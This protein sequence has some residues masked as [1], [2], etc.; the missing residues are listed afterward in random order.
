MTDH[1]STL[2][3]PFCGAEPAFHAN[4][5]CDPPEWSVYCPQCL[6]RSAG[7][8]H[9]DA[10]IAAWN[11]RPPATEEGGVVEAVALAHYSKTIEVVT[12]IRPGAPFIPW[13]DLPDEQRR[14]SLAGARAAIEAY[15]KATGG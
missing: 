9:Q 3:C 6:A 15:H 4:D 1:N 13:R 2:A 12:V 11:R 8:V 7:N 5:W 14:L 10:A